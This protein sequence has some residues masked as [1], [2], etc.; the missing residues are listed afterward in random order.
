MPRHITIPF[1]MTPKWLLMALVLFV[2]AFSLP[3]FAEESAP[4]FYH[5]VFMRGQIL[6]LDGKAGVICIGKHDNAE[7]GQV[8]DVIRHKRNKSAAG[9][10]RLKGFKRVVVGQVKVTS[11]VD[12]HYSE[13]DVISGDIK[14]SDTVEL[15]RN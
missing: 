2:M 10:N 15:K 9:K 12:D 4:G 11:I 1:S 14:E 13:I 8:L 3:T 6:S 7:V 5:S